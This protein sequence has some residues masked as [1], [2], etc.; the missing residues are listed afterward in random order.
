[1]GSFDVLGNIVIVKFPK[2]MKVREKKKFAEK[3]LKK[4]KSV[5]TVLEKSE[6]FSGR[7]RTMKT[8][9]VLGEKTKD[10]LYREN[11]CEFRLNVDS[12]YFSPRLSTERK[13]IAE[14][15][16]KS[17]KK[18]RVLVMFS[19]V[20][21]YPIVISKLSKKVSEIIGVELGRDCNR[22]GK[23]NLKRNKIENVVLVSGDVRKKIGKEKKVSGKFD[24]IIMAR[25]N[26]RDSFLDKAFEVSGKG[27]II[28]YY[29]FCHELEC[30]AGIFQELIEKE[31]KKAKKKVKILSI[32]QAGEIAPYK[33]RYRVDFKVL[34]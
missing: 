1:M 2:D 27:T 11:S 25:P 6:K 7:L 16:G 29:G 34:N 3:L 28:H 20:G 23:E 24:R 22:Y 19:G 26:L 13:E 8:S 10:A 14:M 15:I 21:V 5:R 17:R 32:K 18:E 31:A 30:K 12:C 9:Y 4:N 33:Y